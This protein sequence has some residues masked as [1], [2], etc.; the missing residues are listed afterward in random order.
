MS[1]E[2]S[3]DGGELELLEVWM[4][5]RVVSPLV[6]VAVVGGGGPGGTIG[7]SPPN[8]P[9]RA[10][11]RPGSGGRAVPPVPLELP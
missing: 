2:T 3:W 5:F 10:P 11:S 1:G 7:P 8:P 9:P 6:A 4:G